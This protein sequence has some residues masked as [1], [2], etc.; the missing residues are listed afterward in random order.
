MAAGAHVT[1]SSVSEEDM[2][3]LLVLYN[4]QK[5]RNFGELLRTAAAFGVGEVIVVGMRKIATQGAH[6]SDKSLRF[7]HV[8][9]LDAACTYVRTE[10]GAHICG[11]EIVEGAQP[12]GTHPF[13][14]RTGNACCGC[15][16]R[17]IFTPSAPFS[18]ASLYVQSQLS[19]TSGVHPCARSVA[20]LL[21]SIHGRQRRARHARVAAG[22][23]RPLCLHSAILRRNSLAE[24]ERCMRNRP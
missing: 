6:G 11:I 4:V 10:H 14:G 16:A 18:R 5:K 8:D 2:R 24:C 20:L 3:P 21:V 13:R 9:S 19:F 17:T 22:S 23:V 12:V 15:V 7:T 1:P